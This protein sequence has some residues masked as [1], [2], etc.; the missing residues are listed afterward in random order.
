MYHSLL[1][2]LFWLLPAHGAVLFVWVR[3]LL[4]L[5]DRPRTGV[6][7]GVSSWMWGS[8]GVRESI[9]LTGDDHEIWHVFA[10]LVIVEACAAGKTLDN[11]AR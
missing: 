6:H 9:F 10:I 5:I 7:T 8:A 3:N 1:L 2:L 11:S 4:V